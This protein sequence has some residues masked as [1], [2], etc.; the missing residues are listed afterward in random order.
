MG[1]SVQGEL[2]ELLGADVFATLLSEKRLVKEL[3]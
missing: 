2:K 1:N 3:W